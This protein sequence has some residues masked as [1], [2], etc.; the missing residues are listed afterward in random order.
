M[1]SGAVR[2]SVIVPTHQGLEKLPRLLGSLDCQ[3]LDRSHWEVVFVCNGPDDGSLSM[4][5]QW[6]EGSNVASRILITPHSGAGLARNLGLAAAT[7]EYITFI[8]DDDWIEPRFLEVGLRYSTGSTIALL[9]IKENFDGEESAHNSLNL[10]RQMLVGSTIPLRS[11]PWALGF[12][13]CKFVPAKKLKQFRYN[14]LLDS[15]EDVVFFANLLADNDLKLA[16]PADEKRSAYVRCIRGVSVSRRASSFGFNVLQ[17]LDV[18][19]SLQKIPVAPESESALRSLQSAQ[20]GFV[21][22]RIR[23]HPDELADAAKYAL[24]VGAADLDWRKTQRGTARSLVI[25][26]CFAPF[27]DPGANV[28]AKRIAQRKEIVDVI[29]AD[30]GSVRKEDPTVNLLVDPWVS[31]HHVI[32]GHPSFSSWPAIA[33]FGKKAARA[34]NKEYSTV[35]SR[36]LWSG[37]HVAGVLYKLKHPSVRWEAEFS[38]P[39]RWGADGELRAS[40]PASGRVGAKLRHSIL[41]AGWRSELGSCQGNHF[42]LTE[43]ATLCIA[44]EVIFTN[45]NQLESILSTYSD[46]FKIFV[47]EKASIV[48][49]PM[50]P[51]E[52]YLATEVDLDL[53]PTRVNIAY[54]GQFY[55]NRGIGDFAEALRLIPRDIAERVVF[56]VFTGESQD[57]IT[58]EFQKRRN[59]KLHRTLNYLDFLSACKHF[60]ALVVI[61]TFTEGT[62]YTKNPFL[63]SKVSDYLGSG[64]PVWSMFEPGSPLSTMETDFSS[65]LGDPSQAAQELI[66]LVEGGA[67]N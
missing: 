2:V 22:D 47:K 38:D 25:S 53:D 52:A 1:T 65:K 56:H 37:S 51:R 27:A 10:R 57:G 6:R 18:I 5:E 39:M 24:Q 44:D 42:A 26:Y 41:S 7:G 19:A 55:A 58:K 28:V 29:S 40:E 63:P 34:A 21:A 8:D 15:G 12:N 14:E 59:F 64:T 20:F 60:D 46:A 49:Q 54:F 45:G 35:Y 67:V 36:A 62:R 43:L 4:L 66:R 23:D 17:R 32:K 11:A 30:M 33:N 61:D 9:P 13:A 3:T 50:P 48:H 16:V 31:N